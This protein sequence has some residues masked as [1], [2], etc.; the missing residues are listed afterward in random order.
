MTTHATQQRPASVVP[1]WRRRWVLPAAGTLLAFVFIFENT[2]S[3]DIRLL[4][5][6]VTTP[7]WAALLIVWLLGLF[8]GFFLSRRK[9]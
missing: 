8:V 6:V 4:V 1:W 2:E 7:L 3:T 5:P 9:R